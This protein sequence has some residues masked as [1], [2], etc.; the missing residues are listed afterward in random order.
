MY[1]LRLILSSF[2][3]FACAASTDI[4]AQSQLPSCSQIS[5][6]VDGDG[7][8]FEN[9]MTCVVDSSTSLSPVAGEC[10]DDNADGW[11]WNGVESCVV[12]IAT[13]DDCMDTDPIGDG[14]GWNGTDSCR[15]V[16]AAAEK[17]T[18]I[19]H[20]KSLLTAVPNRLQKV[21]GM[22]CPNTDETFY[23][24]LNGRAE[25]Y[26][27]SQLQGRGMWST[28]IFD[29]DGIMWMFINNGYSAF[30]TDRNT[31]PLIVAGRR[32]CI[33]LGS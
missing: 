4:L 15:V 33:F 28:G 23:L 8:G 26:I 9:D 6:D 24:G 19:G 31:R 5:L 30:G 13:N 27:G 32:D 20:L 3:L 22:F 2:M 21:V 18:E 7:F 11:G 16:P 12:P 25:H 14:W 29:E 10:V 17:Y 1:T